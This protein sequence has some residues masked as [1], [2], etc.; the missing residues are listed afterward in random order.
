LP[1]AGLLIFAMLPQ[2][3]CSGFAT[4]QALGRG[5]ATLSVAKYS[6]CVICA[7][8]LRC[9]AL[10]LLFCLVVSIALFAAKQESAKSL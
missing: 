2:L 8:C 10:V 1:A 6:G 7:F 4:L 3:A 9:M 5:V